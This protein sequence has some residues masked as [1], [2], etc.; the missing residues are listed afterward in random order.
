MFQFTFWA[1]WVSFNDVILR[2]ISPLRAVEALIFLTYHGASFNAER[3]KRIVRREPD[4][5]MTVSVVHLLIY[6][7]FIFICL[8]IYSTSLHNRHFY[9]NL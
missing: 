6:Y 8:F 2:D 1:F 7:Y 3:L 4:K 9:E 5:R